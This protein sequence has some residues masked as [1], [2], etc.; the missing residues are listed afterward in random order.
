MTHLSHNAPPTGASL[1]H[2]PKHRLPDGSFVPLMATPTL[3]AKPHVI[4][5][6]VGRIK[7]LEGVTQVLH[8]N[9]GGLNCLLP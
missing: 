7:N 1:A 9:E 6:Y 4:V 8:L 2:R 5:G 3:A